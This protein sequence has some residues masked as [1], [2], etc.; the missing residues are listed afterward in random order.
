MDWAHETFRRLYCRTDAKWLRLSLLARGVGTELLKVADDDGRVF[1]IPEEAPWEC[2]AR[3]LQAHPSDRKHLAKVV[4]ELLADHG[5]DDPAYLIVEGP[6]L[7]IRNFRAAQ[8]VVGTAEEIRHE[9]SKAAERQARYRQKKS[10]GASPDVT[11]GVTRDVTRDGVTSRVTPTV[12]GGCDTDSLARASLPSFLPSPPA[13][14]SP[15]LRPTPQEPN[16][17]GR[18]AW[19]V[20]STLWP[21]LDVDPNGSEAIAD[22]NRIGITLDA[23]QA[24]EDYA[25]EILTASVG[26]VREK[27]LEATA[28][29]R[30]LPAGAVLA[31]IAT[32]V[33]SKAAHNRKAARI[34][35][36]RSRGP[37]SI[38]E[39][40][41]MLG[42]FDGPA[43]VGAR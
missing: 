6:A 30:P 11:E 26:W 8:G 5:S 21:T 13:G 18:F 4:G 15:A 25:R 2:V 27:V 38:S 29:G 35:R 40:K 41:R 23:E 28:N 33:G 1:L 31:R 37:M 32:E 36:E 10:T 43:K 34:D 9:R 24:S 14:E 16:P 17:G 42:A 39:Q 12:T 3:V 22:L 20:I 19:E 7:R